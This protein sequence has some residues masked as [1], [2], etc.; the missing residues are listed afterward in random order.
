MWTATGG[1]DVLGLSATMHRISTATEAAELLRGGAL[2]A[3]PT[4]GLYGIAAD[5]HAAEGVARLDALKRREPGRGYIAVA[6]DLALMRGW[7]DGD[8]RAERLWMATWPGPLT[9]VCRRG[10]L[11][12]DAVVGA[13]GTVALRRELH[14]A[15]VALSAALGRPFIS[16]SLNL[17]GRPPAETTEGLDPAL[18]QALAGAWD[19]PPRPLG[20]ASTLVALT[21]DGPRILRPGAIG[22]AAIQ[23]ELATAGSRAP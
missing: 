18:E 11:A 22:L 4:T 20:G 10:P 3:H 5:A 21:P 19:L 8:P 15:V 2:L 12:P 7:W 23:A 1:H 9:L 16:T 13:D 6:G 17:A 14:P